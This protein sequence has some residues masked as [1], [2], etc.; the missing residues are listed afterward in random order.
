M[1][2][3]VYLA[4]LFPCAKWKVFIKLVDSLNLEPLCL[5]FSEARDFRDIR[6]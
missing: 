2:I 3:F 6:I 1:I 4:N 5:L